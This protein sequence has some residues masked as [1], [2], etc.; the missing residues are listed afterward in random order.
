MEEKSNH[1]ER[2]N[3]LT[4]LALGKAAHIEDMIESLEPQV[5]SLIN[6]T[7]RIVKQS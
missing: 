6:D 4:C 1:H 3:E 7:L 2:L 5:L